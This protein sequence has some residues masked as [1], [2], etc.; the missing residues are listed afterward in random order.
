VKLSLHDVPL[1]AFNVNGLRVESALISHPG[2]TV[3][4][5]ISDRSGTIVY[6]PDHE[7]ALG[8]QA[9]PL[10][11]D[12]TSGAALARRADLLIH[13]TQYT[14]REYEQHVGWGH[15]AIEHTVAFATLTQVT[16]L[17]TFHHDPGHSDEMIDQMEQAVR[18]QRLPFALLSG[19]EDAA[20]TIGS[21][22][23]R[24]A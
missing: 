18:R 14:Q 17:L 6:L 7:P 5:R 22:S 16:H 21:G 8:A 15:S 3:G 19:R 20:F 4:Y 11:A 23:V 10:A 9:F 13:D 12:W 1:G 24:A 2:P